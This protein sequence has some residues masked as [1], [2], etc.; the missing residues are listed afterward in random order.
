MKIPTILTMLDDGAYLPEK[1]HASDAG[2]DLRTPHDATIYPGGTITI[3]T[4]VHMMI[5]DGYVG[6]IES[7]S[8]LNIKDG[9]TSFGVVD[10]GYTGSIRVKL[11][12][13]ADAKPK[14]FYAG[15]KISQ[16][17]ILPLPLLEFRLDEVNEFPAT[18]RG[19]KGFGSTGR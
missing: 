11:R 5:P 13:D 1:A 15:D 12:A 3:D 4:G 6:M 14:T 10:A 7:K 19:D 2:Y 9:L 18:E 16:I 8:G 17:V